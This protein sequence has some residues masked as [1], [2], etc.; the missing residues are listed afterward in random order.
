MA[1]LIDVMPTILELLD[2]EGPPTMAGTSL[3][4]AMMAGHTDGKPV[5]S[6]RVMFPN[7]YKASLR[8]ENSSVIFHATEARLDA[9][10]LNQDPG[11]TVNV[12]ETADFSVPAASKLKH[13]LAQAFHNRD[14]LDE[15]DAG[16]NIIVDESRLDE[17]QALGYVDGD[18]S[19]FE[20]P[21]GTPLDHWPDG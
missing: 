17:L 13:S 12:F 3:V 11:E 20:I 8:N 1:S 10:D 5:V 7:D 19:D 15:E 21:E 14:A 4:S 18:A 9:Y 2:I 16:G 6:E